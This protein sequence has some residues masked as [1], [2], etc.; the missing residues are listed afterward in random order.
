MEKTK[1]FVSLFLS[2]I[3]MISSVSFSLTS[4]AVTTHPAKIE[5]GVY[6]RWSNNAYVA[7]ITNYNQL[8]SAIQN[9]I[10]NRKSQNEQYK[11]YFAFMDSFASGDNVAN[12]VADKI[13]ES[14]FKT[15]TDNSRLGDYLYNSGS[16]NV[17]LNALNPIY[18]TPVTNDGNV[19]QYHTY[20][21]IVGAEYLLTVAEEEYINEFARLFSNKYIPAGAS[22]YNKVKIIYDFVIRNTKYDTK[23]YL[24]NVGS[25]DISSTS[26]R[27][28]ISHS[29]YGALMG[30]RLSYLSGTS[31]NLKA[32]SNINSLCADAENNDEIRSIVQSKVAQDFSS[33][34]GTKNSVTG[35]KI[36]ALEKKSNGSVVENGLAVCE[37]YSKLFNYLCVYNGVS[38]RIVDG[39]YVEYISNSQEEIKSLYGNVKSGKE[40]DPHEWNYVKLGDKWYTVDTTFASQKSIKSIDNNNYDFFLVGTAKD[41]YGDDNP[42]LSVKNHQQPYVKNGP[43]YQL[44]NWYYSSNKASTVDY[45]VPMINVNNLTLGSNQGVIIER[46]TSGATGDKYAYILQ[47]ANKAVKIALNEESAIMSSVDGFQY[48]GNKS[49]QYKLYIPY[50]SKYEYQ[51]Q[52]I[53]NIKNAGTHSISIT[54][55][56]V[57]GVISKFTVSFKIVPYNMSGGAST[58]SK[59]NVSKFANYIGKPITPDI[60]ITDGF[61]NKLTTNDYTLKITKDGVVT[62]LEKMGDYV[63]KINFKGNYSGSYSFNFKIGKIDISKVSIGTYGFQYYPEYYRKQKNLKTPADYF[64]EGVASIAVGEIQLK[65]KTDFT[66]SS[67]GGVGYGA[68]GSI[69]LKSTNNS[70]KAVAGKSITTTYSIS[71]KFD[72]KNNTKFAGKYADSNSVNKYFYNGTAIKP[73]KFDNLDTYLVK[74]KDYRIKS[75]SNNVNAGDAKVVIEG[76]N[77]CKGTITM[78]FKINPADITKATVTA[79]VSSSGAVS[80]TVKQNNKTLVKGTDYTQTIEKISTGY[81]ITVKGKNNYG[82]TKVTKL[83]VDATLE[84]VKPTSSGNKIVLSKNS[85]EYTGNACKPTVK[86]VNGSGKTVNT[87]YYTVSYS[88]NVKIGAAKVT[89]TFRNGYSGKMT[90]SFM[91][92]PKSTTISTLTPLSKGFK[93]TW[94]KQAT[95]TTGYQIQY[96]TRSD[97]SNATTVAIGSNT[98]TSRSFSNL[99][100]GKKYYVRIRTYKNLNGKAYVSSWSASKY[101]VTK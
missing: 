67:T 22:D 4:Y 74:G 94:K 95:Q 31:Y 38:S 51:N 78:L 49:S 56:N 35:Q 93:V 59:F 61:N 30:N 76:I 15:N 62:P 1:R 36:V 63:I 14:I 32:S 84:Y 89:L 2:L 9:D 28:R 100:S 16:V 50:L 6:Y 24:D 81:K 34:F 29:A 60:S 3:L 64:N 72:I 58:G 65:N 70:T 40:S 98:A 19:Y 21:V 88:S 10:L 99:K 53:T 83:N 55:K 75:Y 54:G 80:V 91:I 90:V 11:Y 96:A 44:Y 41:A 97:F 27:Y 17:S 79:K 43:R 20:N 7:C 92:V 52:P 86:L 13:T 8:I 77:G 23:L 42:T 68:K 5:D 39:D 66:V 18:D 37:G 87:Y 12:E 69:T 73:T 25:K 45:S 48:N 47:G 85:F 33:Y 46:K 71:Q 26:D 82:G 101:V 57:S